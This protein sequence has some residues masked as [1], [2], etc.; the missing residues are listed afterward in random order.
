MSSLQSLIRKLES[1]PKSIPFTKSIYREILDTYQGN[2]YKK[3][4]TTFDN[5]INIWTTN[6]NTSGW[7]LSLNLIPH[8]TEKNIYSHSHLK[9]LYG[10]ILCSNSEIEYTL[11]KGT[12]SIPNNNKLFNKKEKDTLILLLEPN[13]NSYD[14]FLL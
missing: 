12:I 2:D 8:K 13:N 5:Y 9:I 7:K 4:D 3:Y 11:K 14:T 6:N 1:I 10:N